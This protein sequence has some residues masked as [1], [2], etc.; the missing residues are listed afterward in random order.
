MVSDQV[1]QGGLQPVPPVPK[2]NKVADSWS[3]SHLG[4]LYPL[5]I[6]VVSKL[7]HNWS[8]HDV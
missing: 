7:D 8:C 2:R 5:T 4:D 1:E 6:P 3:L